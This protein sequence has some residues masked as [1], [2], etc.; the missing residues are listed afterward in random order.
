MKVFLS[1]S[2]PLSEEV[3]KLLRGWLPDV[4][5]SVKPYMSSTDIRKGASWFHAI[6][7]ELEAS[8]FGIFCLTREN[9]LSTWLNFE[10]G[11]LAKA[12]ESSLVCPFLFDLK[13]SDL[14]GPLSQFQ[15]TLYQRDDVLKLVSD[16]NKKSDEPLEEGR[17][18][19][20]F[21]IHWPRLQQAMDPLREQAVQLTAIEEPKKSSIQADQVLEEILTLARNLQRLLQSPENLIPREYLLS[22]LKSHALFAAL[23]PG[24]WDLPSAYNS[25]IGGTKNLYAV[26]PSKDLMKTL[27]LKSDL[28]GKAQQAPLTAEEDMKLLKLLELANSKSDKS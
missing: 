28:S 19:R 14:R 18:S 11:A 5:Q 7:Q 15:C 25:L 13:A 2:G 26:E 9:T 27:G 21:E 8:S 23:T 12:I 17:L 24:K 22:I 6:S 1:W 16:L 4:I 10:A 20:S 3:A